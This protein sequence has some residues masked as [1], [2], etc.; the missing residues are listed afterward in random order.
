MSETLKQYIES[1]QLVYYKFVRDSE[2][3]STQVQFS[4][5][6]SSAGFT[7]PTKLYLYCLYN[8]QIEI[9]H[10]NGLIVSVRS[11]SV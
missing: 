11:L 3:R 4:I 6:S 10:D 7:V 9:V 1:G 2:N 8:R 5:T